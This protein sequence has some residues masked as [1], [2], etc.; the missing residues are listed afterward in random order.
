MSFTYGK[1]QRLPF[2]LRLVRSMASFNEA[3]I[4]R[5]LEMGK[6]G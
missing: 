6:L 2:A 4:V 5:I 3:F 1:I